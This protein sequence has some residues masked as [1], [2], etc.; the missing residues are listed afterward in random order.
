MKKILF[1]LM[2]AA[3]AATPALAQDVSPFAGPYAG[4]Q[5]TV[6][7]VDD[8]NTDL[9][10]WYTGT[11]VRTSD[12][13][14][15]VG[16]RAG[17]D[18]T[19]G[20]LLFGVLAEAS[21]GKINSYEEVGTSGDDV[22]ENGTK[23][24]KLGSVRAKLGVTSGNLAAFVTGGLAFSDADQRY[25]ETD[26]S[27]ERYSGKGDRSGYV[28]GLGAAYVLNARTTIGLDYSHYEF[29]SK[30]HDL[31]EEDGSD[32]DY[33]FSEDYKVRALTLSV[34]FGF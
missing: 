30:H 13:G 16:L 29:G 6:G 19:S 12:R 23:I 18:M 2:A 11:D 27:D 25:N 32:T 26:G 1:G 20:P 24:N 33:D 10:Y 4:I 15:L 9:D 28:L 8:V 5:G 22:F 17:Y 3:T 31:R 7:Q 21:I 14:L 34:N